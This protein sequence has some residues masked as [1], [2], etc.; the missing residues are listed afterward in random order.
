MPDIN[1]N[2]PMMAW[3]PKG[4]RLSV[5]YSEEGHIKLFV[6]DI[7]TRVKPYKRDLTDRLDEVEEMTY[8]LDSKTLLFSA[9]LNGHT[10]IFTYDLEND[11]LKRVTNDIYDDV[12]AS[13]VAFP[14]KIGILFSSNRPSPYWY[15]IVLIFSAALNGLIF[16]YLSLGRIEQFLQKKFNQKTSFVI[17]SICL[18]LSSFGVY[19]GRYVRLNS[20]NVITNPLGLSIEILD[21]FI[22]PFDHSRTWSMTIILTLFSGVFYFIVKRISESEMNA[23]YKPKNQD[24]Y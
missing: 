6:Y 16:A 8:S 11:K 2:Y 3:D 22:Y 20:W 10:D 23:S 4:T 17:I 19:L 9:V 7:I 14:G 5:L 12:D 1:P 15:D 18:F 21:R 13:F 24:P